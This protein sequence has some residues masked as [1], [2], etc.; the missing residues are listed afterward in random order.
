MLRSPDSAQLLAFE[1]QA[2]SVELEAEFFVSWRVLAANLLSQFFC[3]SVDIR[4]NTDKSWMRAL[5]CL[6]QNYVL[7]T[8][9]Q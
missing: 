3:H 1:D 8:P 9:S 5:T 7:T 2:L 4:N 6:V